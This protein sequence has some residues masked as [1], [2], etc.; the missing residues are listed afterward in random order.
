MGSSHF[1]VVGGLPKWTTRDSNHHRQSVS[2]GKTNAIPT[3]GQLCT[4]HRHCHVCQADTVC[5]IQSLLLMQRLVH[6]A[7]I[8]IRRPP[9]PGA[10]CTHCHHQAASQQN[11]SRRLLDRAYRTCSRGSVVWRHSYIAGQ[12][13]IVVRFPAGPSSGDPPKGKGRQPKKK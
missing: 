13:A 8:T 5:D 2:A 7:C 12:T 1:F 9:K 10:S 4:L 3:G 6:R 11:Y